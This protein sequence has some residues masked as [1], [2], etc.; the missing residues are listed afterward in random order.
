MGLNNCTHNNH[1]KVNNRKFHWTVIGLVVIACFFIFEGKAQMTNRIQLSDSNYVG[2]NLPNVLSTHPLGEFMSRVAPNFKTAVDA[3]MSLYLGEYNGN[4]FSPLTTAYFPV[5]AADR[6]FMAART[7]NNRVY[8]FATYHYPST[9]ASFVAEGVLRAYQMKL[10]IPLGKNQ[11]ISFSPRMF[12]LDKGYAPY[13]IIT[14]DESI[15]WFHSNIAGGN[16]PFG[17]R[18]YGFHHAIIHYVD[19]TGH[20]LNV[21]PNQLVFGG[22]ESDYMVYPKWKKLNKRRYFINLMGHFGL[23]TTAYN[24][25]IDLG[26]SFSLVKRIPLK[27]GK[28]ISLGINAGALRNGLIQ[29]AIGDRVSFAT[30]NWIYNLSGQ[31]E[32]K[33]PLRKNR[34]ISFG[35]NYFFQSWYDNRTPYNYVVFMGIRHTTFWPYSMLTLYKHLEGETFVV[36]YTVGKMYY[37]T[38][39]REDLLVDNSP[40]I[41]TGFGFKINFGK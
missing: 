24:P 22:F 6:N 34:T 21:N 18:F 3:N 38:Y 4:V 31:F 29:Y 9:S 36:G 30:S 17:R 33:K 35:L 10:N 16:D 37:F 8:W 11:E 20:S 39:I 28:E 25:T 1:L 13:S 2:I 27:N 41:Q 26:G 14:N 12:S 32:Y 5:N 7:W 40:D 19:E 23:N 15:E